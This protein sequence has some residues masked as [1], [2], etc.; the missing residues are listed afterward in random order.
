MSRRATSS[1]I[2]VVLLIGIVVITG[3]VLGVYAL[4][5]GDNLNDPVPNVAESSGEFIVGSG[6]ASCDQDFVRLTHVAGDT[7]EPEDIVIDVEL[8]DSGEQERIIQLP[9]SGTSFEDENFQGDGDI[10][11][12][13][14]VR[15]VIANGGSSWTPGTDIRF[16]LNRGG[17]GIDE[18]DRIQIRIVHSP[19]DAILTEETLI[20]S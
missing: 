18:G 20:A 14:C 15:G 6:P 17:G 5:L 1:V 19:S 16:R 2:G 3:G 10:V 13:N 7:V 9:V 4:G 8:P 11:S 12:N